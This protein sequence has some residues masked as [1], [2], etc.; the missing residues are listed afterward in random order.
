LYNFDIVV[1]SITL[2]PTEPLCFYSLTISIVFADNQT[3]IIDSTNNTNTIIND[4]PNLNE[5]L[6]RFDAL[7]AQNKRLESSVDSL[8]KQLNEIKSVD[9]KSIENKKTP[10][11]IVTNSKEANQVSAGKKKKI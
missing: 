10:I 7:I 1:F 3:T 5:L 11:L 9:E 4:S 8:Q 2:L 6:Q